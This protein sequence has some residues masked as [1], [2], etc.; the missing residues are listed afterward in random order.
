MSAEER[1]LRHE[2][3]QLA[4]HPQGRRLLQLSLRGLQRGERELTVGCWTRR[5]GSGCLFQHAYWQGV[6]ERVLPPSTCANEGIERFMGGPDY[7]L[8]VRTI[9]AF[10]RLGGRRYVE[11]RRG[12]FGLPRR[13][14]AQ[15][16]WRS[17]VERL[18]IDALH[19][20]GRSGR[21]EEQ[22][23]LSTEGR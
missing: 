10:D 12:R 6:D 5:T 23:G 15:D 7:R 4:A 17:T 11:H 1:T 8:V 16:R 3:T 22:R 13:V 21:A 20:S 2:L 9:V 14:L 19:A 18:L